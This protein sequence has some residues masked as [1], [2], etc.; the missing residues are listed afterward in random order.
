VHEGDRELDRIQFFKDGFPSPLWQASAACSGSGTRSFLSLLGFIDCGRHVGPLAYKDEHLL[1][2]SRFEKPRLPSLNLLRGRP[3]AGL[4]F[5]P[6]WITSRPAVP[7]C[8]L[9]P[10]PFKEVPYHQDGRRTLP[11]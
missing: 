11:R 7:A 4:H 9:P 2:V 8:N 1:D 6:I 5:V 3:I 10:I